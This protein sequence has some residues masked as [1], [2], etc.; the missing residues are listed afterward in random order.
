LEAENTITKR[1]F[2]HVVL[3]GTAYEVGQQQGVSLDDPAV[4]KRY[5][6]VFPGKSIK[7]DHLWDPN[8][9]KNDA[10]DARGFCIA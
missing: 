7:T 3:E 5:A 1:D 10:R 9:L 6:A 4:V 8:W 2:Q